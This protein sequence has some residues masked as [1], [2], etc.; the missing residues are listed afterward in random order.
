MKVKHI[1]L[2]AA[3]VLA[4][5]GGGITAYKIVGY[6]DQI[7][8]GW[9][10]YNRNRFDEAYQVFIGARN[11]DDE[12][13]EA[14]IGCGWSLL[15]RQHPDSA[16]V[17]FFRVSDYLSTPGD[18]LDTICGIAASYLAKGDN[19]RTINFLKPYDFAYLEQA[20]P[21]KHHDFFL[22]RGDLEMV[23]AQAYYRL[24][25]YSAAE[26]AD[27]DNATYHLNQVLLTPYTY[28][29]PEELMDKMTGY[30]SGTQGGFKK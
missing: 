30:L 8:S 16:L 7:K 27:P 1:I 14:Y 9:D 20:F 10:E 3:L 23:F 19:V 4:G 12:L 22:D 5:C 21:L 11:M 15:M 2:V 18:S 26:G 13:P 24:E 6:D 25:I 29:N 17:E 28:T